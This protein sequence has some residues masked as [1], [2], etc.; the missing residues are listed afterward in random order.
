MMSSI[1]AGAPRAI[2]WLGP[3]GRYTDSF[4]K[5]ASVVLKTLE[6][7]SHVCP[8]HWEHRNPGLFDEEIGPV[9]SGLREILDREWSFRL[10]TFQEAVLARDSVVMCGAYSIDFTVLARID[11]L[12]EEG[13]WDVNLFLEKQRNN[14]ASPY[15]FPFKDIGLFR[16][17]VQSE[18]KC[19]TSYV[20]DLLSH[21]YS[22]GSREPV[23][24]IWSVFGLLDRNLQE[25]LAPL[26]GYSDED[27]EHYWKT[28]MRFFKVL[29]KYDTRFEVLSLSTYVPGQST[30]RPSWCPDLSAPILYR[31]FYFKHKHYRTGIS[32]RSHGHRH[33]TGVRIPN[34]DDD[35]DKI[36]EIHGFRI[37]TVERTFFSTVD[38]HLGLGPPHMEP[39]DIVCVLYGSRP[40]HVLRFMKTQSSGADYATYIGDAYVDGLMELD[41]LEGSLKEPDEVFRMR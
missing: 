37:A 18:G 27:R 25:E 41:E 15:C 9:W 40:L 3:S 34:V 16:D 20:P 11:G 1:F 28:Y 7:G 8:L 2:V 23:D 19:P 26:V 10:W 29:L 39:G 30:E 36:L 14:R 13:P 12:L 4:F 24:R 5:E 17:L 21:S 32:N 6:D 38:G 31:T 33:G 35:N 22:L